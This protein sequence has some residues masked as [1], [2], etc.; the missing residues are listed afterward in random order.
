M[1]DIRITPLGAGQDVGRSCILVSFAAGGYNVML[2]CGMHMGYNDERR[3][4][5]FSF[6][7]GGT[8]SEPGRLDDFIDAVIIS[9]FHLDHCGALPYMSE[10]VGYNG[11]IYMTLP[12]RALCPILIEDFRR[13]AVEAN[14]NGIEPF[15][16]AQIKDCISKVRPVRLMDWVTVKKGPP[17]LEICAMYAG[18]VLGA[19]MFLVRCGHQSVLYTGDF[20]M[21]A[22]RHL[23]PAKGLRCYPDV[24]ISE[25]TYATTIRDSK[26]C[27]ERD[28]L[29]RVCD[30]LEQGGK[31]L[32]PVFAL[33]RAQELCLLLE[34]YWQRMNLKYPIYVSKG[35]AEAANCYYRLF[36]AW[37]NEAVKRALVRH[38]NVFD[39]KHVRPFDRSLIDQKD[40]GPMVVFASPGMLHA[41]MSL[42]LFKKWADDPKNMLIIP[43]YCTAGTVGWKVLQGQ[44]HIEPPMGGPTINVKLSVHYLSF[45]AHADAKGILQ[46]VQH[47]RP[48]NVMLVHGEAEKMN[49]MSKKINSEFGLNSYCPANGETISVKTPLQV[50]VN[51]ER[52]LL[53]KLI[54]VANDGKLPKQL[55]LSRMKL[56]HGFVTSNVAH[57]RDPRGD[58]KSMLYLRDPQ[59]TLNDFA[60]VAGGGV[61]GEHS[62]SVTVNFQFSSVLA[63]DELSQSM[64]ALLQ[65]HFPNPSVQASLIYFVFIKI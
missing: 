31:V 11:P 30:C 18:H 32:I 6:V 60:A 49:Y 21:T 10:V 56:C 15:T 9:H 33:G 51:V 26:R 42:T 38:H 23:G 59:S 45:S 20:N 34:S 61:S 39:F 25:S 58:I 17:D 47:V 36:A 2:D 57:Q 12:T 62:L 5:D 64:S 16:S 52:S 37:T 46:L 41:G 19:C 28:L 48:K 14:Q 40:S 53:Q 22:D 8:N 43:G 3:F 44:K 1:S 24:L 4:P 63:I 54:P 35:L 13:V 65:Q 7:S 50:K 27:R 29:Q 55:N